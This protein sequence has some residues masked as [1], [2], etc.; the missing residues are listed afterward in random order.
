LTKS[1][2][3]A[4]TAKR[5]GWVGCNILLKDVPAQGKI[6]IIE[7]QHIHN[8]NDV[9]EQYKHIQALQTQSIEVRGWMLDVLNCINQIPS[10]EFYLKDVYTFTEI[11]SKKHINNN[12]VEAKIRQQLQFLRDK[13]FL[14]FLERGHYRKLM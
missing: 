7:N 9:I 1:Q 12:N 5:A 13:G 10:T 3:L 6:Q 11:L 14:E 8:V 2:P 4:P